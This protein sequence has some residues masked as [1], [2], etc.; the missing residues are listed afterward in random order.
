MSI[1]ILNLECSTKNCSVSIGTN[2]DNNCLCEELSPDFKHSENLHTFIQWALEGAELELNNMHA[3]AVGKGPGSYTG[4]RIGLA[5]AKGLCVGLDIPLISV[6]S[7]EILAYPFFESDYD[8]IIPVMDARRMEVY[9]TVFDKMGNKLEITKPHILQ[10]DSFYTY[11]NKTVLFVGDAS[12]KT[13]K[14]LK[15]NSLTYTDSFSFI[16]S[17]PSAENMNPLSHKK[18]NNK[19]FEDIAYFDPLYLKEWK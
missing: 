1:H 15:E 8:Y 4:L 12:E 3:I 17:Y 18:F 14:F 16:T 6:D 19:S 10:E 11:K 13:E 2:G 9:T 5:A 7:L